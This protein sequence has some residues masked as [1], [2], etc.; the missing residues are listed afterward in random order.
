MGDPVQ[1]Y[2]RPFPDV[3]A[4]F[5]QVSTIYGDEAVRAHNGRELFYQGGNPGAQMVA[6]NIVDPSFALGQQRVLFPVFCYQGGNGHAQCDIS[7]DNQRL[8]MLKAVE[9]E[10]DNQLILVDHWFTELR[11]R[12]PN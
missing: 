4:G 10:A 2:V 12:V 9:G 8:V 3:D 5:W 7:P 11:E 6:E 1:V